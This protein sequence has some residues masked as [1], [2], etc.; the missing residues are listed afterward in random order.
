[1]LYYL[2]NLEAAFGPLRIF[3]YLT[4]RCEL[5]MALAFIA[6]VCIAPRIIGKMREL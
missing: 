5:A 1:M 4:V 6:G 2:S 3:K